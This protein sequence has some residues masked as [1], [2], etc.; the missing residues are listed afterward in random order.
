MLAMIV[1]IAMYIGLVYKPGSTVERANH[2]RTV[3]QKDKSVAEVPPLSYIS[4]DARAEEARTQYRHFRGMNKVFTSAAEAQQAVG[5]KLKTPKS[6][7][8]GE[9]TE[10]LVEKTDS[11]KPMVN[12]ILGDPGLGTYIESIRFDEPWDF[13]SQVKASNAND[14]DT[15]VVVTLVD[16]NGHDGI[17]MNGG[18]ALNQ[19]GAPDG[20]TPA[21]VRWWEDGI[22]YSIYG[23]EGAS[24]TS[25][26]VLLEVARS[27]K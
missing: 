12:Q 1:A 19:L 17:A 6:T 15:D 9:I 23:G 16:I 13:R 4:P 24:A 8:L 5:Y 26:D 18:Y 2:E 21:V 25:T 11:A 22:I 14:G 27:M 7:A 20:P 3:E 10:V